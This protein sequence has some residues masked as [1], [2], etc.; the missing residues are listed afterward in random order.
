M[1]VGKTATCEELLGRLPDSVW[2]DGDWCWMMNPWVFSEE[3]KRM[4]ED[5]L[6]E[7]VLKRGGDE[8]TVN[9]C[10]ERLPLYHLM[11]TAKVDTTDITVSEAASQVIEIIN[12]GQSDIFKPIG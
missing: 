9:A 12:S 2:L 10:L 6:R 8:D 5:K 11:D 3:N 1:C 7:R 4:V